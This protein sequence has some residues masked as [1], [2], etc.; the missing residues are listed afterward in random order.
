MFERIK[1]AIA[2]ATAGHRVIVIAVS[3]VAVVAIVAAGLLIAVGTG[4]TA[5]ATRLSVALTVGFANA[6]ADRQP[7]PR[8]CGERASGGL[9]PL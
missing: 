8:P 2:R 1:A 7:H 6:G 9:G 5:Q 4:G 3:I